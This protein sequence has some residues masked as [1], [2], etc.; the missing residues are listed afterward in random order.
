MAF[1]GVVAERFVDQGPA[2]RI[3]GIV[4]PRG[5]AYAADR[6]ITA[7]EAQAYHSVQMATL[8]RADVDLVEAMTFNNVPEAVG[9]ARA[10]AE[11]GLPPSVSFPL[12][13]SSRLPSAPSL[14]QAS[15]SLDA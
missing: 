15:A 11:V 7:D 1:L 6:D 10:A 4:G 14:R 9:L 3:V 13:R 2:A 5:D 12:G 8:A